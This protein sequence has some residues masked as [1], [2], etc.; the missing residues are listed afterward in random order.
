MII[1]NDYELS[2]ALFDLPCIIGK[3]K[4]YP[5]KVSEYKIFQKYS[6][7]IMFSKAHYGVPSD[8]KDSLL[9]CS[10]YY[11]IM[12][13]R[14]DNNSNEDNTEYLNIVFEELEELF[15]LVCREQIKFSFIDNTY[16]FINKNSE[17][18]IDENNFDTIRKVLLKLNMIFE[19][20]IYESELERK[21]EEKA[22]IARSK[23]N[24][25]FDFVDIITIVSCSAS[26]SYKDIYEQNIIQLYSDYFRCINTENSRTTSIFQS[27]DSKYKGSNFADSMVGFLFKNPYEG[28][29]KD[30]SSLLGKL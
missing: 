17:V 3:A 21:W 14:G 20:K 26:K 22:M 6:K 10:I 25:S 7:Y 5:T 1:F 11:N 9:R 24:T 15:S 12:V 27:V 8:Y 2:D 4:I 28:I 23:K 18:I 13:L 16:N 19:P 29:W 30:K